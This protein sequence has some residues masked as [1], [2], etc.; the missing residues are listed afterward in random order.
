[1]RYA[2]SIVLAELVMRLVGLAQ[3]IAQ[4]RVTGRLVEVARVSL[5]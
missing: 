2:R 4:T 1:M 3:T 5:L